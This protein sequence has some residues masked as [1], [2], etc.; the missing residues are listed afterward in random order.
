MSKY[1]REVIMM[2]IAKKAQSFAFTMHFS[3]PQ[4][5]Y[6]R[7]LSTCALDSEELVKSLF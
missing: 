5:I 4:I 3:K 7:E 2:N 1:W 6:V